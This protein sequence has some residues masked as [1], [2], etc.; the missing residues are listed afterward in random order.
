M[1][2]EKALEAMKAGKKVS[3]G[4][5]DVWYTLLRET[6]FNTFEIGIVEADP[7]FVKWTGYGKFAP[8]MPSVDDLLAEDW[9]IRD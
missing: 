2:F 5:S 1:G 6:Q 9:V 8:W 7:F 4:G 3:R